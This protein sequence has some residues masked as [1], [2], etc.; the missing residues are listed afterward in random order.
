LEASAALAK[1]LQTK[2]GPFYVHCHHGKHRGPALGAIALRLQ[3][4]CDDETVLNWLD[5]AGVSKAYQGLWK[6]AVAFRPQAVEGTD[7]ELH[8]AVELGGIV[9]AMAAASRTWDRVKACEAAGWKAPSGHA[10]VSPPHEA[11]ILNE[12]FREMTRHEYEGY[13]A[14]EFTEALTH[15]VDVTAQLSKALAASDSDAAS[16]AFALVGRSCKNCHHD[17][18]D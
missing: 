11:V 15:A 9:E 6:D 5:R 13:A 12:H 18:R 3:T 16:K 7:P 14:A 17:W 10:D 1:T 2:P 4:Q 8:E